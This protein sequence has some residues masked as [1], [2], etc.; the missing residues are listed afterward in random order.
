ML[1]EVAHIREDHFGDT[2][3][4]AT[5]Y[6]TALNTAPANLHALHALLRTARLNQDYPAVAKLCESLAEVETGQAGAAAY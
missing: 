1:C 6:R 3:G 5:L 4:A 2:E